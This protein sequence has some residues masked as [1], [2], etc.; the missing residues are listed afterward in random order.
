VNADLNQR[1]EQRGGRTARE[2][3]NSRPGATRFPDH[4]SDRMNA[5]SIRGKGRGFSWSSPVGVPRARGKSAGRAGFAATTP[6]MRDRSM[7]T[8][9]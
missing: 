2:L 4:E 3:G 7:N 1:I 6:P 9:C 8:Y 5:I